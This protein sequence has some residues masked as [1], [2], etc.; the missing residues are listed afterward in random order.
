MTFGCSD[1]CEQN[2][3]QHKQRGAMMDVTAAHGANQPANRWYQQDIRAE[4]GD[5]H[6]FVALTAADRAV[7][8]L[9]G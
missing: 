6:T 3:G 5:S 8:W 2:S 1:Q 9:T 4:G 7:F